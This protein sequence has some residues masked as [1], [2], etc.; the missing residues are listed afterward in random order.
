MLQISQRKFYFG[1]HSLTGRL[2]KVAGVLRG[3]F[4]ESWECIFACVGQPPSCAWGIMGSYNCK[5]IWGYYYNPHNSKILSLGMFSSVCHLISYNSITDFHNLKIFGQT[6]F[7][8]ANFCTLIIMKI[9]KFW[10]I[11]VTLCLFIDQPKIVKAVYALFNIL[12]G[13]RLCRCNHAINIMKL[14]H[15]R[16]NLFLQF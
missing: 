6:R 7:L 11:S 2:L 14:N 1:A 16:S 10:M 8:L 13:K 12:T 4:V 15:R 5:L 9:K 3:K